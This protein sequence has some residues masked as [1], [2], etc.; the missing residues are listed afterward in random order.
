[1]RELYNPNT[2]IAKGS[3]G[4][5]AA[6]WLFGVPHLRAQN[7]GEAAWCAENSVS[8]W[9]KG[10]GWTANLYGGSQ[11]GNDDWAACFIPVN[12]LPVVQFDSALWSYYMTNAE[13]MGV[14][15][16]IWIHDPTDFSK[17]A[18]V[19]QLGSAS[20]LGKAQ[21]WNSHSFDS[22]VT[23]MFFYGENTTGTGLSEGPGNQATWD[24]FQADTLFK[25]WTIYRISFEYGWEA[26]GTFDDVWLAEVKLNGMYIELRPDECD[27]LGGET[28]TLTQKTTGTSTTK[29]TMITPRAT[30]RVRILSVALGNLGATSTEMEVYFGT[31]TDIDSATTKAIFTG[32]AD[33]DYASSALSYTPENGPVGAIGEVVSIRTAT[34]ITTNGRV[35]ISYRQ[36]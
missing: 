7:N 19:T 29:A 25:N 36:E 15:I 1:M 30:K 10:C 28:K 33:V 9:Q 23:Q 20:G 13:T 3:T 6:G 17:R 35:T 16:V 8:Q 5:K 14:N 4:E 27:V 34:D 18:E 31:G 22:T 26:S 11:T 24:E 21:Y 32:T 12:E 2:R